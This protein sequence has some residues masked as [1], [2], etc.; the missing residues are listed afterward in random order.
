MYVHTHIYR[1][2]ILQTTKFKQQSHQIRL[3][4]IKTLSR[5][6]GKITEL[7]QLKSGFGKFSSVNF[8]K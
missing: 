3:Q 4:D 7:S 8:W 2:Y 5:P 6:T 1:I